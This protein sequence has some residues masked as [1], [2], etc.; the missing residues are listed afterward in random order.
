MSIFSSIVRIPVLCNSMF[1]HLHRLV[2]VEST[3]RTS[4]I[5]SVTFLNYS[6][7]M[8]LKIISFRS[9]ILAF[10]QMNMKVL[11]TVMAVIRQVFD[12]GWMGDGGDEVSSKR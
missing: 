3:L 10:F 11:L 1:L 7:Q 6:L 5:H 4:F 8:H 2:Q 12:H 9:D